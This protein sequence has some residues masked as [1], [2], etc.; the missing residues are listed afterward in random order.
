MGETRIIQA[1][2]ITNED[3]ETIRTLM[4]QNPSWHR[5]RLSQELCK[6]W[7]WRTIGGRLKDMACRSMLRKLDAEGLIKLPPGRRGPAGERGKNIQY[8][9][10]D[11]TPVECSLKELLPIRIDQA[12]S[13]D[14]VALF[15]S[16]LAQ[17]HYLSY[18]GPVGE[19]LKYLV[20]G[21]EGTPLACLLFG[22]SAWK[23]EGRDKY[24]GWDAATRKSNLHLVTNNMRYLI[25]PW[26]RVK[27]LASHI[28][29]KIA[30]RIQDDWERKYGYRV[31]L[32]E[33]FVESPRF[34]GTCYRASNWV[35]VGETKGRGKM[36]RYNEYKV[37]VKSIWLYPL[38]KDF[39]EVLMGEKA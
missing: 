24:I 16:H 21:R 37:P 26:V 3:I 5:T 20:Y 19:N 34:K 4:R 31:C 33:T 29:G 32:L 28:L 8:V 27:H 39:R 1:R 23:V 15:T 38:R 13:K 25:L 30:R 35:N 11:K 18:R 7:D 10:H 12:V 17:Y 6:M 14:E 22:A 2:E 36:D 9:L